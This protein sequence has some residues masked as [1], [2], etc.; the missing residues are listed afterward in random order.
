MKRSR[1]I[2]LAVI[3]GIGILV[4]IPLLF[5]EEADHVHP[6]VEH[7]PDSLWEAE[8]VGGLPFERPAQGKPM[9]INVWAS[10]CIPCKEEAPAFAEAAAMY[11]DEI[12]FVGIATKDTKAA[13]RQFQATYG[14]GF[15]SASDPTGELANQLR[16]PALPTTFFVDANG[17]V[18]SRMVKP[19]TAAELEAEL[20]AL[21][22]E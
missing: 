4:L 20:S 6:T 8:T 18:I 21:I 16:A 11:W 9:V 22:E 15:Q 2:K 14:I 5:S 1:L 19:L 17:L 10:W 13:A 3:A 12:A 7:I